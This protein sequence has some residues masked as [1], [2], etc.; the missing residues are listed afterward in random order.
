MEHV[1]FLDG[2]FHFYGEHAEAMKHYRHDVD[3][4]P[5]PPWL[6]AWAKRLGCKFVKNGEPEENGHAATT[7]TLS[8]GE[9]IEEGSRNST[10]ASMAGSM[11]KRGF[12][13]QAI[14]AAL[15]AENGQRCDPPLDDNEVKKIAASVA[16]YQPDEAATVSVT[17]APVSES[18]NGATGVTD[19]SQPIIIRADTVKTRMVE[20]LWPGRIPLGKMTTFAGLG[21]LG[22]TLCLC[23]ITAR[24]TRGDDWPDGSRNAKRGQVLFVSGEDDLDDTIVPRLIACEADLSKVIF[25]KTEV[26]DRFLLRDVKVL[27]TALEQAGP[28]VRLV[29]IDPP[30]A[31][32]GG[33][34]DHKNSELRSLLSPLKSFSSKYLTSMIFNTHINKPGAAKV[35]A[36]MR[37]MGSV[38]W[39]NAVRAAHMFSKDPN[40]PERRLFIGMKLN[41]GKE[42]KGLAY[43]IVPTPG[44]L[45]RIEW[46]GEVDLTADEAMHGVAADSTMADAISWLT[47][48][49]RE[50]RSWPSKELAADAKEQ[51]MSWRTIERA[52]IK[53]NAFR[54]VKVTS[55]NGN[56]HWL[57][58]AI[59]SWSPDGPVKPKT[60]YEVVNKTESE[61]F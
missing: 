25:L 43:K 61:T 5:A 1:S 7:N 44:D 10:L 57:W 55:S 47:E 8:E 58:T 34:D 46:L 3:P 51:G 60:D 13:E 20:W 45:A 29:V 31:Y 53:M 30:T 23:D 39:V 24:V 27:E 42:Q 38:A 36:M 18:A 16:S 49:F 19:L 33:V 40:D 6:Y 21:G 2:R 52:K 9:L 59:D 26:A 37:V 41:I 15:M 14:T 32:L 4:A 54:A 48:R 11:R 12:S 22:K 17:M 50:Q 35:E 56:S 28:D